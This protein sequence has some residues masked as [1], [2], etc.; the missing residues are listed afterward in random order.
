MRKAIFQ[1]HFAVFLA[2]FS[3]VMGRLI[4]LNEVL[5]VF[6]RLLLSCFFLWAI[7]FFRHRKGN[8][9]PIHSEPKQVSSPLQKRRA[10]LIGCILIMHW[11]VF[12]AGIKY[13]NIS[14]A[15]VC[16]SSVGFF[17]ALLEP[18]LFRHKADLAEVA[19]GL[20]AIGGIAIIFRFDARYQTGIIISL[21]SAFLAAIFP[22]LNS[23]MLKG[24]DPEEGSRY[25]LSGGLIF[26]TPLIPLYLKL[27]PAG[28][29]WPT[30]MD[31]FWLLILALVCTVLAYSIYMRVLQV[32]SAFTV[33]LTYSLE[34]VYSIALAF[35][36]F[37]E[38][39]SVRGT[40]YVGLVI[41]VLAVALQMLRLQK[42]AEGSKQ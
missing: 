26:L 4:G 31:W 24:M 39:K 13:S 34:P 38:D 12:Y 28:Y 23:R 37:R 27:S 3:G 9:S 5:I 16:F 14:T 11:V 35:L 20:L 17:T 2:G 32:V 33:N 6:Y 21:F 25:Q 19:L 7:Y 41:I 40:F 22:I 30:P 8:S 10:A 36:I 15:L 1:L 29:Y 42:R 18:L